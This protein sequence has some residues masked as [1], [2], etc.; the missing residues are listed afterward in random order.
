MT[1]RTSYN[2]L[3]PKQR[4]WLEN[5]NLSRFGRAHWRR[6]FSFLG[7][8]LVLS[9][10]PAHAQTT[11]PKS[12]RVEKLL[13]DAVVRVQSISVKSAPSAQTLGQE[14]VGSGVVIGPSEVLTIGYLILE[15]E[16]VQITTSSGK[17]IS[18][19]VAGYDHA[20]GFG[21]IRTL[22]PLNV[23]PLKLGDSDQIKREQ[24]LL[25]LGQGE[26]ELTPLQVISRKPFTGSWEYL[27]EQ[28]I[29]TSPPVNNWSGSALVTETGELVGI[30]SLV[31]A[32][33]GDSR[34]EPGNLFVPVNLLKPILADLLAKG[35]RTGPVQAW[36]GLTTEMIADRLVVVRVAANSPA[37][38][39]GLKRGDVITKVGTQ[40]VSSQTE[41]Y[42]LAWAAGPAGT[43][44][45]IQA[46]A[47]GQLIDY[48]L[49][50][51][52]RNRV[53]KR[54]EGV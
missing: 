37:A 10:N 27:L 42:R 28:P 51:V 1:T 11:S 53:I 36:F 54:P 18:G 38:Q 31:L 17:R 5:L 32:D 49:V 46:N 26:I 20:T 39:S 6:F 21:I 52:D 19:V 43:P 34:G 16:S 33:A 44:I 41:F 45:T 12:D 25:N 50:G 23:E 9:L 40:S 3:N 4:H 30:G 35:Y 2:S 24:K 48:T 13:T 22:I 47:N 8:A 14:R 15:A 7:L 29:M